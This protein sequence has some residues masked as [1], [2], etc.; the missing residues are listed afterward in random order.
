MGQSLTQEQSDFMV[1]VTKST[2]LREF[3]GKETMK[4]RLQSPDLMA[5]W[6]WGV[7]LV[8]GNSNYKKEDRYGEWITNLFLKVNG[9][10]HKGYVNLYLNGADYFE[11]QLYTNDFELVSTTE[12]PDLEVIQDS[13]D[14]L[15]ES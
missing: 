9:A 8:V 1:R 10:K 7:E 12:L 6:S 14:Q 13:I 4:Y 3:S 15:I 5:F 2:G 11:V